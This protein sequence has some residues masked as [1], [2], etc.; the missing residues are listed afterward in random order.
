M[1]YIQISTTGPAEV[2][3]LAETNIPVPDSGQVLIKVAAAGV[4]RLD[5]LQRKGFYPAPPGASDIPGVEVAGEIVAVAKDTDRLKPGDRVCALISG[6]GYAEYTLADAATCLPIPAGISL[7]EAAAIP[8][9]FFTVWSNVFDRGGLHSDETF[10]VHGGSSGIGST[11]IQ[12]AKA[13]GARVFTT[14]GTDEKCLFCEALGADYAINYRTQ[15]Y[16]TECLA[17]TDQRGIHLILDMVGGEY[18]NKNIR[19]ASEEGRIVIIAALKGY[20]TE[21]DILGIMRKR[22]II[23]GSTL[24]SRPAEFKQLIAN[25]LIQQV[26]PLLESKLVKPVIY[27]DFPLDQAAT[28]HRLM[29]SGEHMGKIVLTVNT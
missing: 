1:R 14:A 22:L 8:E 15:D 18:L 26:W 4:N 13:F 24:R 25:K 29:E 21:V 9:A 17:A 6:G 20:Q 2:L 27:R 3:Q 28:A 10:L 12:L 11:A 7:L 5:I 23:T 16:V 19:V